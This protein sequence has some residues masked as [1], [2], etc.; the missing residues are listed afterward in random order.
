MRSGRSPF[1]FRRRNSSVEEVTAEA[2]VP[3]RL[4]ARAAVAEVADSTAMTC[5]KLLRKLARKEADAGKEVPRE[6][7]ATIA[8]DASNQLIDEPAIYLKEG[9]VIHTIIETGRTMGE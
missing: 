4:C 9:A 8:S 1:R 2:D 6:A 3:V 7:A 5:S